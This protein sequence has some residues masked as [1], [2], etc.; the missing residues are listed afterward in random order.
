MGSKA[1]AGAAN[2]A[3]MAASTL[4]RELLGVPVR[5]VPGTGSGVSVMAGEG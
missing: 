3:F 1:T 4:C 5:Q 2:D